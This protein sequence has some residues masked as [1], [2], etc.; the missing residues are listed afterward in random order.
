MK[1]AASSHKLFQAVGKF[2][3]F[4]GRPSVTCTSHQYTSEGCVYRPCSWTFSV[5]FFFFWNTVYGI[6]I[7]FSLLRNRKEA[8]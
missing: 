6:L 3:V 8:C 4:N 5:F 7:K 2:R 1:R